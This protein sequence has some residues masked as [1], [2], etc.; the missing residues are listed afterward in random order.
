MQA[1][2]QTGFLRVW[3][4]YTK[5][6]KASLP[7]DIAQNNLDSVR[8][9][10]CNLIK[11]V[12]QIL[13]QSREKFLMRKFEV[14]RHHIPTYLSYLYIDYMLHNF[15]LLLYRKEYLFF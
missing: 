3:C 6:P 13:N 1:S 2:S 4:M 12:M 5:Y 10:K 11:V 14:S 7:K 15:T 8:H 9:E